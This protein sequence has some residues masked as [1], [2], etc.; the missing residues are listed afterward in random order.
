MQQLPALSETQQQVMHLIVLYRDKKLIVHGVRTHDLDIRN[1]HHKPLYHHDGDLAV[2]RAVA[3]VVMSG[4][5]YVHFHGSEGDFGLVDGVLGA[6][7][8]LFVMWSW[9]RW[10]VLVDYPRKCPRGRLYLCQSRAQA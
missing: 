1:R 7:V 4:C 6:Y 3:T 8:E 9:L 10:I 2:L 5:E